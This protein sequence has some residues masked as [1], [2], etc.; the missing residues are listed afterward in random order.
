[1]RPKRGLLS[2]ITGGTWG[3]IRGE[4]DLAAAFYQF[5]LFFSPTLPIEADAVVARVSLA[6]ATQ[7]CGV[8]LVAFD[9]SCLAWP[10]SAYVSIR[11]IYYSLMIKSKMLIE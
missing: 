11:V 8:C 6:L 5:R 7:A 2:C 9:L 10:K 1:M 4:C 3:N